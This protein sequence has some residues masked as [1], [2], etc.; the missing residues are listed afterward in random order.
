MSRYDHTE[1]HQAAEKEYHFSHYW[2]KMM[3]KIATE[4]AS[5]LSRSLPVLQNSLPASLKNKY[6]FDQEGFDIEQFCQLINED[7][8]D[9]ALDSCLVCE[10]PKSKQEKRKSITLKWD[11]SIT[12]DY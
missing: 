9:L 10:D 4:D 8:V 11:F 5:E 3:E 6:R 2:C 7:K 1:F 12:C